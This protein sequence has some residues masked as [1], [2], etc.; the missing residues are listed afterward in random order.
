MG[1]GTW[2]KKAVLFLQIAL[3]LGLLGVLW[4]I[5]EGE[6]ALRL[7]AD[8]H[9]GW[10]VAACGALGL[11]TVLS[12]FR[13]R[14][15]ARQLGI[16][17]PRR[18]A[19]QEYFL[20][21]LV[22]QVLP[23]GILGDASRAVRARTQAGL[24]VSAQAVFL[25]RLAG[26]LGL[27]LVMFAGLSASLLAPVGPEWPVRVVVGVGLVVALSLALTLGL[28]LGRREFPGRLGRALASIS[29]A[30]RA[31]FI[32][33]SV[34]W[35]QIGLSVATALCNIAG[36]IFAAWAIGSSLPLAVAFVVVPMILL[37]MLF[38]LTISGWGVREGVAV[39]LFVLVG[40]SAVEGLA[41][42]VAFGLVCIAVALPGLAFLGRAKR[43]AR[44]STEKSGVTA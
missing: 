44:A 8:A 37:A 22:N 20:A 13:W 16:F 33:R 41:A 14:L 7:L 17:L 31:A 28:L 23:G 42:S 6:E 4:R 30:A 2:R 19:V 38:P 29:S 21:Q 25:E 18:R 12:G 32:P 27:F 39:A 15:T 43:E 36:F 1:S 40:G 11:Q 10:L 5:A 34:R 24:M 3:A 26:Q 9:Y 35:K